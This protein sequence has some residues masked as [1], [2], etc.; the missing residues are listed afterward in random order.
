[1]MSRSGNTWWGYTGLVTAPPEEATESGLIGPV[2][3]FLLDGFLRMRDEVPPAGFF[4]SLR[5]VCDEAANGFDERYL[6]GHDVEVQTYQCLLHVWD[7]LRVWS[8]GAAE[9]AHHP[10][11]QSDIF[12]LG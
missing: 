5:E 12:I 4:M 10:N 11:L 8:A 2:F 7:R 9:P 6:A 1:M 3:A